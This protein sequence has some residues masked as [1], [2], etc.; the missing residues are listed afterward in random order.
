MKI[1]TFNVN[2][3]I[4][5]DIEGVTLHVISQNKIDGK[6][7]LTKQKHWVQIWWTNVI[8]LLDFTKYSRV[9]NICKAPWNSYSMD[10]NFYFL[11][12]IHI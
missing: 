2:I 11:I 1:F 7:H 4:S 9:R 5:Q 3:E 10:L 8:I 6:I 12:C